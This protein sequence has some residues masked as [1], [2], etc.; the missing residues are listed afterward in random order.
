MLVVLAE[1]NCLDYLKTHKVYPDKFYTDPAKFKHNAIGFQ[2]ATILIIFAGGCRF[3]KKHIIEMAKNL[4]K[5]ADDKNDKGITGVYV[6]SDY[7]L[8]TLNH[9][10]MY[11]GNMDYFDIK[12]GWKVIRKDVYIW[13]KLQS[14]PKEA[15]VF[16]SSYDMANSEHAHY[17]FEH[18][19]K[20]TNEDEYISKIYV[21][22][23][24]EQL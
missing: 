13:T 19:A 5:R 3:R 12:S 7:S 24:S 21:P 4:S 20:E 6:L 16:L 18:R 14:E 1:I 8:P 2:D 23:L 11:V 15:E 9:Y 17:A 22:K 10:Y